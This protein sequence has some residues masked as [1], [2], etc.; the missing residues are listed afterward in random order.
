MC[1][2]FPPLRNWPPDVCSVVFVSFSQLRELST[3][4][5]ADSVGVPSGQPVTTTAGPK[6]FT[7]GAYV[8]HEQNWTSIQSLFFSF[9]DTT[10][11]HVLASEFPD[12]CFSSVGLFFN[13]MAPVHSD[14]NNDHRHCN[15]LL[16]GSHLQMDMSGSRARANTHVPM[17]RQNALATC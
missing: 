11:A 4:L 2:A 13:L 9:R 6:S 7:S 1:V 16:P 15:L 17:P 10:A 14:R 5:P 12:A 8:H 3:H